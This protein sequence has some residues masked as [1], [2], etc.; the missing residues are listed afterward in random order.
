MT[1]A[2]SGLRSESFLANIKHS[3]YHAS[4]LATISPAGSSFTMKVW[5]PRAVPVLCKFEGLDKERSVTHTGSGTWEE[6]CFDFSAD[7]A[8]PAVT[9][10]TV[11]F[12]LGVNGE[13]DQDAMQLVGD[14]G[15][16]VAGGLRASYYGNRDLGPNCQAVK[17]RGNTLRFIS[18][19]GEGI[20][21]DLK[22][23]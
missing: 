2:A 11:I 20:Y 9:G 6:L 23:R 15:G 14:G 22:L 13:A 19:R 17:V 3:R 7:T 4:T 1:L 18:D 10:I 8:G 12:D 5:S 21:A 16:Y